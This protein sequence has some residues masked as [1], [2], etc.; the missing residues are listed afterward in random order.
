[1][2]YLFYSFL[3]YWIYNRFFAAPAPPPSNRRYDENENIRQS[4]P[5]KGQPKDEG[6]FIDYEE[7]K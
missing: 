1:M 7:I 5:P 4:V 6:E 3:F 2:K